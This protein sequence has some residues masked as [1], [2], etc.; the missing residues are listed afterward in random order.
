MEMEDYR[1]D[2][3]ETHPDQTHPAGDQGVRAGRLEACRKSY[4]DRIAAQAGIA[5]GSEIAAAL[6]AIP[7]ERFVGPAPWK[8]ASSRGL[9]QTVSDDPAALYQDAVV[10]L[11]AGRGLDRLDKLNNG[12][13]SLHAMCL[14]VLAPRKGEHAVQV[15]AGTGY[16]TAMLAMLVGEAGRVDAYEIEPELAA[17]AR[18]NLA[19]FAQVAVHCRSGAEGPLPDCDVLYVNAAASEPLAVWLD[20]LRPEGRLLFPLEPENEGGAMLL[21]TRKADG[22]YAARFLC[23]VQ[24]VACAGAQDAQARRALA[25][26][27]RRGNWRNVRWLH[28]NDQPDESC[29]C[30]GHGWWLGA[31]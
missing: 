2:P 21:V 10:S 18:A 13:P 4:A 15:G 19:E 29:W 8:I 26:A 31:R 25:A 12:Q 1:A 27:F 28:R 14:D 6:K 17:R 5:S 16:Y 30:A 24:F 22:V 23:G 11:S 9:A 3:V 20:A 7:R